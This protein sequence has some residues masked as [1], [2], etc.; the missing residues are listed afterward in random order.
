MAVAATSPPAADPATLLTIIVTLSATFVAVGLYVIF[1]LA[2]Y[3]TKLLVNRTKR[4]ITRSQQF[5][6]LPRLGRAVWA[7]D[8]ACA[9]GLRTLLA[10]NLAVV[11]LFITPILLTVGSFDLAA[12]LVR[13]SG[14]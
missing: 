9:I 11:L 4:R 7:I 13:A 1:K 8:V 12:V 5:L 6:R 10:L 2:D 14:H 3:V